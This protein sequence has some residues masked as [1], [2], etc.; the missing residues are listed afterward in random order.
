MNRIYRSLWNSAAQTFVAAAEN[1]RGR[2]ARSASSCTAV[3]G[4][5]D[6]APRRGLHRAMLRPLALEQRFMFDGAAVAT[7]AEVV[8]D[9]TPVD[10]PVTPPAV[11]FV[12]ARVQDKDQLVANATPN[13]EVVIL[14]QGSDGL[15]QIAAYLAEHHDVGSVQIVAHGWE[16][17]LWLG[18]TFVDQAS[19]QAHQGDLTAIGQALRPGG[20][21]LLYACDTAAGS[22]GLAFVNTLSQLT[23]ADV[24]AS[25]NRSGSGG[26]WNLEIVTGSIEAASAL[27]ADAMA[28]YD[29]SLAT[30]TVTNNSDSYTDSGSIRYMINNATAGDTITF[31]SAMTI[32]VNASWGSLFINRSLTIDGDLNDDGT[33]DVI[34]DG[35]YKTGVLYISNWPSAPTVTLD[36]LVIE[37]GLRE[38]NGGGSPNHINGYDAYGAGIYV[39]SGATTVINHCQIIGN[40]ATGG[41]GSSNYSGYGFGGGGGSGF[42]GNN[43]GGYG[44]G[45]DYSF[46]YPG[47]AASGGNGGNGGA[48]RWY[49]A[50]AGQGGQGG[51]PGSSAGGGGA[52]GTTVPSGF[53]SGGAGGTAGNA[54]I[55]FAGGGGGGS[56]YSATSVGNGGSAAGGLYVESGATVY[57][58]N[59]SFSQNLGAGGGGGGNTTSADGGNGGDAA[60]AIMVYGTV[61]YDSGSVTFTDNFGGAGHGGG[62]ELGA[63]NGG[64]NGNVIVTGSVWNPQYV[65][66]NGNDVLTRNT[67]TSDSNWNPRP[68]TTIADASF[69]ND[70]GSSAT[71]FITN[72]TSQTISGTLSTNLANGE[73]VKVSLDNGATWTT[74]TATV[75]SNTWSLAGQ[76][77]SASDTLKVKIT[78]SFGD[79]TVYTHAYT[80]DT[81]GPT[82][83]FSNLA[84]ST[85][86]GASGSDFI[87]NTASQ[88]ITA[89]LSAAPA[90]SDIVYGS[91]DNGATWTNITT[92]V[93]GTTLTWNGISL[94]GSN[95]LLLKVTD[96]VGNDGMV[97]S[98]VYTLDTT[99]P[100]APNAPLLATVSDS[101]ASNADQLTNVT[102]PTITGAAE[103]NSTITLYD[104]NGT[105]LG[106]TTADGS[107][108][109]SITSSALSAGSHTLTAKATDTAGNT[110]GASAGLAVTIDTTGPAITFSALSLSADSGA[111]GDFITNTASQ[112][113][114]ATLSAAPAGTDIVYGSLDNGATWTNITGKV[115]GTTLTWNGVTLSGSNTL[116]LKVTDA[117][118]NDGTVKSQSYTLDSTAPGAPSAPDLSAGSD[119]GISNSDDL[120]NVTTPTFTGTAEAGATVTL[121]DTDGTTIL[122]TAIATGGNWSI[123]SSTLSAG[124]HTLTAK[125]TDVAGNTSVASSGL[126]ITVET[127][128]PTGLAVSTTLINSS[129]ATSAATIAT[130]SATDL[131]DITY[132]LATGNG[133]NDAENNRF[134]VSG[135]ALNVGGTALTAGTYH[136]YVA[137]T[138]AAGNATYQALTLNVVD[139]PSI[140][141]VVRTG[142]ASAIVAG[143]T[144]SITY[145]VTFDQAVTGVDT[146]DFALTA[147]GTAAGTIASVS[148]SGTTYTVTVNSLAGDGT[149]RLDLNNSGTGIQNTS[150]AAIISGYTSGDTYTL[151]RIAPSAPSAPDLTVG[152]DTGRSDTDNVTNN[153]T[154][155]FSGTAEANSTVTLYDTNGTTVLGTATA[156]GTGNWSITATTLAAGSHTLSAKATD[157]VGNTSAAS[158]GLTVTIDTAAPI[159]PSAPD[160][161]AGTDT[162]SSVS[163]NLTYNTTPTFT[164]NAE[165]NSIVTLY[166]TN[167]TTLLGTGTAD[168]SGN[169]SITASALSAGSHSL[170]AKATD[171]A[172]NT[173]LVSSNLNVTIDTTAPVVASVSVPANGSYLAGQTLS[174]TVNTD[175]AVIV[176]SG[177]GTP[178]LVI[179]MGGSAVYASYASGSG[180]TALVFTYTIQAGDTDTNGISVGALQNNGGSLQDAAGN[181]LTLT[182]NSVASTAAVLV[183]TTAPVAPSVPD[184]STGSDSGNSSTDNITSNTTPTFT[185]TAEANSTVKL[186]DTDG[187]TLLGT[188]TA[189]GSGNWSITSTTLA[190]G[191]HSLTSKATDAAGN[192][193]PASS[194]LAITIDTAAPIAPSAPD[195]LAGSDSGSSSTDNLTNNST[196][197]LT[198]S[199]EA[200]SIVTLFDTDGTTLLGTTTADGSGNWSITSSAL[201]TGSHTLTTKATDAAGNVSVASS[202]L[203]IVIDTTAPVAPSAPD[204]SSGS[205]SGSSST[206]NITS[207]TTP[208][209]TGSAEAN[210]TVKLYDT[211]GTTLLGTSTADGS[212]NWSITSA[213]LAEGTHTL[214]TRATDAA[215]NISLASAGLALTIDTSAPIAPSAPDLS[216]GSDSGTSGTDN[217]TSNTT[218]TF[219]GTA[220]ASSTVKLYDTDGTTLLGT[221]TADGSGNWSIT[222]TA[223]VEGTH[224]LTAKATDTAG[225]VSVASSGLAVTIDTT[226]PVAPSAPDLLAGSDSGS[227]STDNLTNNS[228]PTLT[229]SAEANSIVTLFDTDGTTLLGTTTADGSGNWS[230]T[231]SALT[232]GSHTLTT[233]AT[234]AA[235][236][237]S[238]ASSGLTIVIDTTAPVAPS[239]PDMS[240]GSDSGTASTD[241]IT[242]NT[243]PTFNG[244][245]EANSTVKLYDT[246]GTTLLGTTTADASGNWSI[247]S[248]TLAEG[249][250]TLS[251]RATDAAGNI[252]VASSLAVIIDRT[253]PTITFGNL[254]LSS[255]TG[256]SSSDFITQTATQTITATLSAAPA[257]GDVVSG[258]LDGG[259]TWSDITSQVA[260]TTLT[261]SGVT[262][263]NS[264]TLLLKVTD[265]A[266]NDGSVA[267]QAYVLDNTA[268]L[269]SIDA[270]TVSTT[271][272][273][274]T[275]SANEGTLTVTVGG[276]TYQVTPANGTWHL[277]LATA[278]PVSGTL[279]MQPGNI[280][281]IDVVATDTAGNSSTAS[282]DLNVIFIPPQIIVPPVSQDGAPAEPARSAPATVALVR[283]M[284]FLSPE[285]EAILTGGF[286][287]GSTD[288][289]D[290]PL[291]FLEYVSGTG[292]RSLLNARQSSGGEGLRVLHGMAD[293]LVAPAGRSEISLPTDLFADTELTASVQLFARQSNGQ[294]LP[295][296]ILFDARTGKFIVN[297]PRGVSGELSIKLVA[298]D[299]KGHEASTTFKIR[300]GTRQAALDPSGRPGLSE[301]IRQAARHPGAPVVVEHLAKLGLSLSGLN[302]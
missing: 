95:T 126:T 289:A 248:A 276:A 294:A 166:D 121:Y 135:T 27:S 209:F 136:I 53:S 217:I 170:T 15:D 215:G 142:G 138:D 169:W 153:T 162:G 200:N 255:D 168:G 253:A 6:A 139:G 148:G 38:G 267:S 113:I 90:G 101:G 274:L 75:G 92:K 96:N 132:S 54:T 32:T 97:Q 76:T 3:A 21:I 144:S 233:K 35:A 45:G 56:G 77:L 85:D 288:S 2:G 112:T 16:G 18:S 63:Q 10:H 103:A 182:L 300:V 189:D 133:S 127:T 60:G 299:A 286:V 283:P 149:L 228:T 141:S 42:N 171:T 68:T 251:T 13:T 198:G 44:R 145:T 28:G 226:A 187:T 254:A 239:A 17:N 271:T 1:V 297:A 29:H 231:S 5:D 247:T 41:G 118:G 102:T 179:D 302:A 172:G 282:N 220:E 213:T 287:S 199:A 175:E 188:T 67:G 249:A 279:S 181:N 192:I 81:T 211:D 218:P 241:N 146:S 258:S 232:T 242:S 11:V 52:G 190:A 88:T 120:T 49:T 106:T 164:G 263:S 104:T 134:N 184:L 140:T 159:A 246:D 26:D 203:T 264:S 163:D 167:G 237:V 186:Y 243:T 20:D 206:D 235:G 259:A 7:V 227:S 137:A 9:T 157:A 119:A 193:S 89:T 185:G 93:S 296:W 160:L 91:L 14:D 221:T 270:S 176:D 65:D 105:V 295:D 180:S 125:A 208:T 79:G 55:G 59:T 285:T 275:G 123:I 46:S 224:T 151:D 197:T 273:I 222:S 94:P 47:S 177:S 69:S 37:H 84:L 250:H 240:A 293:Q 86:S 108:H 225:N 33:A 110:S 261:W 191:S 210:S 114:T 214:T 116:K 58:A 230:I 40:V 194:A 98:Q 72:S 266:G 23:G 109:W 174:F 143:A 223:L 238:V 25:N 281:R 8:H 122:G 128:A 48:I 124:T 196:P 298:R 83:T 183:D 78:N 64:H 80:L 290:R 155:T 262:L 22:D 111:G 19:L 207:N 73:S 195:L 39:E 57:I 269:I 117:A 268:P 202:G 70:T 82:I 131:Q 51:A 216:A 99:A 156:D 291:P 234:D 36:G 50:Q 87:T 229:G 173:S 71:D 43:Q 301:Q 107:G 165:A 292:D 12:D 129:F 178:R 147:T 278:T 245:A 212:G 34:L 31:S 100:N 265:A 24:A 152:T 62:G 257:G 30:R 204:M 284:P 219:T 252:S 130:L 272:P 61:H 277:D 150:S 161:T 280:Y 158:S 115:S 205:D 236:N 154:P 74:A 4:E 66:V 260:G 244:T 201:T 256:S